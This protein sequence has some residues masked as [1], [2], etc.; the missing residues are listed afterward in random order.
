MNN[1]GRPSILC[2]GDSGFNPEGAPVLAY[3][4]VWRHFTFTCWSRRTGLTCRNP[5]GHGWTLSG[6]RW[7]SF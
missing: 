4:R 1:T 2:A 3:G 6:A 7:R 5:A